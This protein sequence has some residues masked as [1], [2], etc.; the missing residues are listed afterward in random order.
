MENIINICMDKDKMINEEKISELKE[1]AISVSKKLF[2]MK[3][4][5]YCHADD[6]TNLIFPKAINKGKPYT[7]IS[8]QEARFLFAFELEKRGI[9]FSV[10]TPTVRKYNFKSKCGVES[11]G[12]ID[13]SIYDIGNEKYKRSTI[14]EFKA[15]TVTCIQDLEKLIKEPQQDAVLFHV[16]ESVNRGT[17]KTNTKNTKG[18]LLHYAGDLKKLISSKKIKFESNK[19]VVFFVCSLKPQF[20]IYKIFTDSDIINIDKFFELDYIIDHKKVLFVKPNGWVELK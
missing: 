5:L 19:N 8:E 7:R 10:E 13:L 6:Y 17:L 18:L 2:D 12:S 15:H 14:V 11:S 4:E 16:L 9:R 1:I 3:N 20:L